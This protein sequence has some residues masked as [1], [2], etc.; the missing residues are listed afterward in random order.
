[1]RKAHNRIIICPRVKPLSVRFAY[2]S[3]D[4]NSHVKQDLGPV[5][6]KVGDININI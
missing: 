2:R 3:K 5:Y 1:M 6:M 4:L